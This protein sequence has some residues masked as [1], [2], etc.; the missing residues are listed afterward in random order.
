MPENASA[1]RFVERLVAHRSPEQREKYRRYFKLGEGEYG[2]GDEFVGVRMGQ[3][4]ALAKEFIEISH[5]ARDLN[6]EDR[7]LYDVR[8]ND[9]GGHL[10]FPWVTWGRRDP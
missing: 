1:E 10:A 2:E 9:I 6:I 4:F 3:I 7:L 8:N 5:R